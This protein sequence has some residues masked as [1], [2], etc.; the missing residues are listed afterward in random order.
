MKRSRTRPKPEPLTLIDLAPYL[1]FARRSGDEAAKLEDTNAREAAS[2]E[3][4]SKES[5]PTESKPTEAKGRPA[6]SEQPTLILDPPRKLLA[7]PEP[8]RRDGSATVPPGSP[9]RR[10]RRS[11]I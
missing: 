8:S 3:A 7:R 10:V 4:M 6:S 9:P 11:P 1:P 5:K 2:K